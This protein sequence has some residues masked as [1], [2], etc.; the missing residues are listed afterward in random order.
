MFNFKRISA[1]QAKAMIDAGEVTLIDIRDEASFRNGHMSQAIH[2]DHH[3]VQ[4]F[5]QEADLD[6]PLIVCCYHG[7]S[8][9]SAAQFFCEQDFT[10]VYSLDG[11]YT[12]WCVQYP[13]LCTPGD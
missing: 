13:E 3:S 1:Q 12:D 7:N 10:D 6:I 11:G 5:I 2:V 4:G 8:S 9:Q